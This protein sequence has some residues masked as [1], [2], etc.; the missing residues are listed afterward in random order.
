MQVQ[1][2]AIGCS[3]APLRVR[4]L[5]RRP[6]PGADGALLGPPG[7]QVVHRRA[8]CSEPVV[9]GPL[10]GTQPI[11]KFF[12]KKQKTKNLIF[13]V[14]TASSLWEIHQLRWGAKPPPRFMGFPEEGGRLDPNNHGL[15]PNSQWVGSLP[16]PL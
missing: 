4:G 12:N 13:G 14:Q 5:G 1:R 3:A 2:V 16:G 9:G 11:E 7:A 10:A 6:R 15:R 8:T